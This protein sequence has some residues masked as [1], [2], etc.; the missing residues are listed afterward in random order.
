[1][2]VKREEKKKSRVAQ[3]RPDVAYRRYEYASTPNGIKTTK[4]E[5]IETLLYSYGRP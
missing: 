2:G 1:M 3:V 4:V 5:T